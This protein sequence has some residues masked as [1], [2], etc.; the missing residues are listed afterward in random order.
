MLSLFTGQPIEKID[1]WRSEGRYFYAEEA[2][3][4]GFA[5]HVVDS[6]ASVADRQLEKSTI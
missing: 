3:E 2:V 5:D 6:I 1:G 4:Q